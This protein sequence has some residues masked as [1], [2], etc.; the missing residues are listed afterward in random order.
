MRLTFS[1]HE[2]FQC[3]HLWLKKGYDY[4]KKGKS[5]SADDAVIELGVGKNMVTSIRFWLRAF[6]LLDMGDQLT[7]FAQKMFEDDGWDPF[8]EDEASLW[9]LHYNLVKKNYA[10]LYNGVF[11][12]LRK[13]KLEFT[14]DH[15][16]NYIKYKYSY[17]SDFRHTQN[18]IESDFGVFTKM[19]V[20]DPES[21]DK[22]DIITGIMTELGLVRSIS[23]GI[24]SIE[25]SER[26]EIPNSVILYAIVDSQDYGVS[27]NFRTLLSDVNSPGS[28]FA[29][30]ESGLYAKI[31]S[32][33][34]DYS[35]LIVFKDD[36]G[37]REL[38]FKDAKPNPFKILNDY[39]DHED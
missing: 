8:L 12:E 32:I 38:Q 37:V 29:I 5:F 11:N 1:G 24:Y 7:E 36:A 35:D 27:I 9:L 3:R 15:F 18:T 13:E 21:K 31:E 34:Q 39:Y 17:L 20:G 6:G 14:K 19:Y 33:A 4:V 22:E 25:S 30:N 28:I 16:L 10:T 26:K 2:T 23:K